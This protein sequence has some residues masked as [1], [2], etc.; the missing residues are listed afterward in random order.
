MG[1]G[2][3]R[4]GGEGRVGGIKEEGV[5]LG[6]LS[7]KGDYFRKTK[8]ENNFQ[9]LPAPLSCHQGWPHGLH[10]QSGSNLEPS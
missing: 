7:P 6:L 5:E 10:T 1:W 2:Q 4:G 8:I 9:L 3:G